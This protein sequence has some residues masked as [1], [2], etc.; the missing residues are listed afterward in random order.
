MTTKIPALVCVDVE[1]DTRRPDLNSRDGWK[2]FEESLRLFEELR[3][4]AG[5]ETLFNWFLRM[6]P[7]VELAYGSAV[8][9]AERYG[10]QIERLRGA[11]DEVGLHTHAWRRVGGAWVADHGD[12]AWVS[13]CVRVSFDAYERA[14]GRACL[15]FR[16]GDRWMNDETF[17]LVESLGALYE[18][19]LEP[20]RRPPASVPRDGDCTGRFPDYAKVPREPYRPAR[21]DFRTR[22][23]ARAERDVWVIPVS[24]A[25]LPHWPPAPLYRRV[26]WRARYGR[27]LYEPLSLALDPNE[28]RHTVG[29]IV[30]G[31]RARH[32]C[33]V[34]RTDAAADRA[35]AAHLRENMGL[36]LSHAAAGRLELTTPAR[37]VEGR[38]D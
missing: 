19:T 14:F 1:P 31:G 10:A 34:V 38:L 33:V 16:F 25:L 8:W 36:L 12:Q 7:Q 29:A 3:H 17:G 20:G 23:G 5:V 21:G 37:L 9:A 24:T 4:S 22:R 6:D 30:G 13:H 27:R 35:G 11:G 32:L 28:F 15:S 18:L 2:G 26:V